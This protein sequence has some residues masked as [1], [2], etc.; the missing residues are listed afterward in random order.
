MRVVL[1]LY[2]LACLPDEGWQFLI[3]LH[4]AENIGMRVVLMLYALACL[5]DEGWQF[6]ITHALLF[7]RRHIIVHAQRGSQ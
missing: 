1:M 2:V 6:L 5:P 7:F 4:S 3:T